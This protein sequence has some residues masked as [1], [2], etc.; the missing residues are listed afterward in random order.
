MVES[1]EIHLEL[2][3]ELSDEHSFDSSGESSDEDSGDKI[4][5]SDRN[6]QNK[7]QNDAEENSHSDS[8]KED[9]I[10]SSER[11]L[12][13]HSFSSTDEDEYLQVSALLTLCFCNMY[14]IYL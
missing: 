10:K 12:D 7:A 4:Y 3:Y 6:E 14:I 8:C 1:D 5:W 13:M 11:K 9:K 2:V